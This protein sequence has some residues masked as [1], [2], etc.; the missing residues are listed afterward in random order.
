MKHVIVLF[1]LIVSTLAH[2]NKVT[3]YVSLN[4]AGSFQGVSQ[5]LKGKLV[6]EGETLTSKGNISENVI[7]AKRICA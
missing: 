5:K 2:A 3:L 4:P 1:C 7:K 6:K